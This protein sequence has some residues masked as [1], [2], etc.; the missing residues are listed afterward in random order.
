MK[1]GITE[2]AGYQAADVSQPKSP[3]PRAARRE[4]REITLIAATIVTLLAVGAINHGFVSLQNLRFM[5][6]NSVVLSLLA[7][8]QT[9]VIATKGI[10]LSVAPVMGLTAVV[11]GILAQ[12]S[13]LPLI[14]AI[15]IALAIGLILGTLNGLLV[16]KLSI[17]P[18]IVTLGTYSLYSGL[19]F[20]YSNGTDVVQIPSAYATFGNGVIAPWLPIPIP[21]L[22]LAFA[23]FL[24]WFTLG[25]TV[26][27]RAVL[28]I[29][30]N[31]VAAYNAGVSVVST[32]IRV[33]TI[34]GVLAACAG[35]VFLCYT[36]S[37][38]VTTGTGDHVELQSI[39][40][41]LIGGTAIVGGRG[42]MI[43]SVLGGLFLS[44]ILTAL[45]FLH[46]PPI[47]YSAG[48]GAMI[49]ITVTLGTRQNATRGS[50]R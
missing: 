13:G 17:P 39:A 30:N 49:L 37:A 8:G 23:L 21:V 27:G 45:V 25:H 11:T 16:A 44:V 26:F 46:V 34:S 2:A 48:E 47:W 22:V 38:T 5:V 14:E 1:P 28:A 4:T 24:C 41:A 36:G 29:G 43:G 42:N 15:G 31:A 10:D 35:L 33:Y 7:L 50:T 40:V 9:W 6:L 12:G 32:Q 18:I 19:I 20:I 3:R